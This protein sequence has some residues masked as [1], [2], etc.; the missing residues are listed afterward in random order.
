MTSDKSPIKNQW[1]TI[2]FINVMLVYFIVYF[3][4]LI[5]CK[6]TPKYK[7]NVKPNFI[8]FYLHNIV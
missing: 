1:K 6:H 4:C 7:T 3:I 8:I 5:Y 2:Y